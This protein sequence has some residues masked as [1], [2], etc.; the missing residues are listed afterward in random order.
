MTIDANELAEYYTFAQPSLHDTFEGVVPAHTELSDPTTSPEG[1]GLVIPLCGKA[2]YTLNGVSYELKPGVVL[3][4]GAAMEL[5][6]RVMG[7]S[8]WGCVLIHYTIPKQEE[9]SFPLY[10]SHFCAET[11]SNIRLLEHARQLHA[12]T[13]NNGCLAT[14]RS[15]TLFAG[16]IEEV[17]TAVHRHNQADER[18]LIDDALAFLDKSYG[19]E[20]SIQQ[21]AALYDMSAKHFGYLF[22]KHVGMAPS[23]YLVNIRMRHAKELLGTGL[24]TIEQVARSVGF[25]DSYYFSRLFKK[26]TGMA[27]SVFASRSKEATPTA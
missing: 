27:P 2:R 9:S 6:K 21:V 5:E 15:R 25:S 22:S 23:H 24:Y 17:V 1:S 26:H 8:H 18:S 12:S 13:R 16:L 14:L 3:H 19:E 10:R 11:G 7:D 4:A 20:L